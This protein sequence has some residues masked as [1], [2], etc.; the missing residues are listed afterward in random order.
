MYDYN[1]LCLNFSLALIILSVTDGTGAG[2]V[3]GAH[4][5]LI[6][7]GTAPPTLR[8]SISEIV[9]IP[10]DP[11]HQKNVIKPS[12]FTKSR[13]IFKE[14]QIWVENGQKKAKEHSWN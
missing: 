13:N 8:I 4:H 10:A 6:E 5:C 14:E 9:S 3:K 2:K 12:H 1:A 7:C 11:E